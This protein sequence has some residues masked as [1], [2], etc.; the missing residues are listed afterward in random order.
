MR[1]KSLLLITLGLLATACTNEEKPASTTKGDKATDFSIP[2][3]PPV[4]AQMQH[5]KR[6]ALVIGNSA[7]QKADFIL[8]NP[9]NDATDLAKVLRQLGFE[10][11]EQ[12]NLGKLQ[13]QTAIDQFSQKLYDN[14]GVGLFD[15]SGHGIQ[16]NGI[17]YMLPVD[18]ESLTARWQLPHK[19]VSADYVLDGMKAA[20]NQI[21]LV[22]L[23]ACRNLPASLK[24]WGKGDMMPGLSMEVPIHC[25]VI[26]YA[27]APGGVA[28]SGVGY[29][30]SP[31]VKH[32]MKWMQ[33]P[34]LSVDEVF[35]KVGEAVKRETYGNQLP[36]YY[37]QLYKPF[38]FKWQ[39]AAP[40]KSKVTQLLRVCQTHFENGRLSGGSGTAFRCYQKV[41]DKDQTNAQALAGLKKIEKRYV[42]LVRGALKKKQVDSAERYLAGLRTVSLGGAMLPSNKAN[43]YGD[44]CGDSFDRTAPV[45]SFAE[46]AFKLY[47]T[48]GNVWEWTCS[49][50]E[51][52]WRK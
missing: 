25:S 4:E 19:T 52:E 35:T 28:A 34:N 30:N 16:H 14:K 2:A 7:Y 24:S 17:N 22:I 20:N 21:N 39:A 29:R 27:A 23:D 9:V 18:T 36:G 49:E 3:A 1:L 8:T 44:Y 51:N 40:E 42:D 13:M 31:Y 5:K 10:V 45:G 11:I 6:F 26:A 43:C 32:L 33:V 37:K 38:Y 50:Y 15:F 46:N 48:V 47:D 41:L 12:N